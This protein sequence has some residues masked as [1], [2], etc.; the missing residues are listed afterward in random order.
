MGN[1]QREQL[2]T[3]Y[4]REATTAAKFFPAKPKTDIY[5]EGRLFRVCAYCRVSTN[6]DEQLS[7]FELQQAHYQQLVDHH[8]NWDLRR[9]YAEM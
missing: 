6:H 7:S 5:G 8:P 4:R 2:R 1:H 9:I 3:L